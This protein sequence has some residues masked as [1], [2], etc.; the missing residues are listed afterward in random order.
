[1]KQETYQD[2]EPNYPGTEPEAAYMNDWL[3]HYNPYTKQWAAF[4]RESYQLYWSQYKHASILR[5]RHLNTL[6]DLLH[7]SKGDVNI[8]EDLTRGDVK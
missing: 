5:S 2:L 8:I 4:P 3:F 6:V 7:K 1:M